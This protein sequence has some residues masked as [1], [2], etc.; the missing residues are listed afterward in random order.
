MN[1]GEHLKY[2][3]EKGKMYLHT[4]DIIIVKRVVGGNE[5]KMATEEKSNDRQKR[6][7]QQVKYLQKQKNKPTTKTPT[8]LLLDS[9]KSY[10]L[11]SES[12]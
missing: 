6:S 3:L 2:S 5:T 4:P 7:K 9:L 1:I 8:F 11:D 10:S 12:Q